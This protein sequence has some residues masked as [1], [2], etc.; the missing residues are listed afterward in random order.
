MSEGFQ[1]FDIILFAMIAG[2]LVFRLR[3]VLGRRTGHERPPPDQFLQKP[4]GN[5]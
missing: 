5:V 2:F 4:P 3:N 1:V